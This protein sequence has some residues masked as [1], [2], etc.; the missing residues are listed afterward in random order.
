MFFPAVGSVTED[1]RPR[2][3]D[4]CGPL[5]QNV[6]GRK[7]FARLVRMSSSSDTPDPR[8]S[9]KATLDSLKT[10]PKKTECTDYMQTSSHRVPWESRTTRCFG[11]ENVQSASVTRRVTGSRLTSAPEGEEGS[12]GPAAA[13]S[14]WR[15][16]QLGPGTMI[17][18]HTSVSTTT[19]GPTRSEHGF[20]GI[21][22]LTKSF[23]F[24]IFI[25]F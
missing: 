2:P 15:R 6:P 8:N 21:W 11:N 13:Q 24:L 23:L 3:R 1:T 20:F 7:R 17:E 4:L 14:L 18:P 10:C 25:K 16:S 19:C 9:S 12:N 5:S 22:W